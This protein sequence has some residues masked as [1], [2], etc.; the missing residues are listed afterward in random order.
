MDWTKVGALG[1]LGCFVVG[2]ISLYFIVKQYFNVASKG[3]VEPKFGKT[4][5]PIYVLLAVGFALSCLTL[6][7]AWSKQ[8]ALWEQFRKTATPRDLETA[9]VNETVG[10]PRGRL[11]VC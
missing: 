9:F 11:A 3:S 8:D 1:T 5:R 7:S 10:M 2:A 6:W 4:L